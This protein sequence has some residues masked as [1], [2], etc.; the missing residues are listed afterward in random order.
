MDLFKVL[1][2]YLNRIRQ[3]KEIY[4][5]YVGYR[6]NGRKCSKCSLGSIYKRYCPV[7]CTLQC[8]Y[9]VCQCV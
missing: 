5:N 8:L 6:I 4:N 9:I 7:K 1:V 3:H 2:Q